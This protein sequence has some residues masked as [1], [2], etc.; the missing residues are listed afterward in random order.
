MLIFVVSISQE[1]HIADDIFRSTIH[2]A[3]NRSSLDRYS[4]PLFFGTDY[5]VPIEVR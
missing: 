4:V 3:T 1:C 2:S 5:H